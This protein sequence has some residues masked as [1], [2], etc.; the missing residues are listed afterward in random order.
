MFYICYSL[1][2]IVNEMSNANNALWS[3]EAARIPL[4][5]LEDLFKLSKT[6]AVYIGLRCWL[7]RLISLQQTIDAGVRWGTRS[8]WH[9]KKRKAYCK[10]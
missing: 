9:Y 8:P 2:Q 10:K 7:Q 3:K 5:L 1:Q 6:E 4:S